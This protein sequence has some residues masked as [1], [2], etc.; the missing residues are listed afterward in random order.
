MK[1]RSRACAKMGAHSLA[2]AHATAVTGTVTRRRP[3]PA[4]RM[5]RRRILGAKFNG[6]FFFRRQLYIYQ[7]ELQYTQ[8]QFDFKLD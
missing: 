3:P 5:P 2:R 8:G 1:G 6:R 4:A 7:G